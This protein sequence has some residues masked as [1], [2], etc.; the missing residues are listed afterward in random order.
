MSLLEKKTI[1]LNAI[2]QFGSALVSL[3]ISVYL[4]VYTNSIPLMCLYIV[5]R[6]GMFPFFFIFGYKLSKKFP[7]TMTYSIGLMLI[8]TALMLT[9]IIG[10]GFGKYPYLV[11]LVATIIGIGEGFYYF[12]A[13][14]CNQ[15]VSTNESR[16]QFLSF[17]GIFCNITSLLAPVYATFVLAKAETEIA[18]YRKILVSI[19]LIFV[20]VIFVALSMNKRSE[21]TKDN[22]K[23]AFIVSFKEKRARDHSLAVFFYGLLN[24]LSLN[25]I[26]I[27]VYDAAGSGDT[28]SKLQ[29]LFSFITIIS[30]YVVRRFMSRDKIAK[31]FTFGVVLRMMGFFVLVFVPNIVGAIA[32]GV[33]NY[34]SNVF[35]DNCYSYLSANIIG[36]Y[37]DMMTAMVVVRETVLSVARCLAMLFVIGCYF[38]LPEGIYLQTAVITLSFSAIIV[39]KILLKY[40]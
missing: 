35:Y 27:L 2:F 15:I 14:T 34:L 3:F 32:F 10:G 40:K 8:T 37:K 23:E 19:I 30:F 1:L 17:N 12:S 24:A 26:S 11:L 29:V 4:Y 20:L 39:E 6:I 25:L 7:F 38:V 28:Y 18:G 31:T 16:N 36:C 21:D 13:N 33:C 5:F 22:L 9:L